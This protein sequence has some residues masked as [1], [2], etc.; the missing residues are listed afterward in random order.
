MKFTY[1][2]IDHGAEHEQYWQGCGAAN[3]EFTQV[4]TGVGVSALDAGDDALDQVAQELP[5]W[6]RENHDDYAQLRAEISE[7]SKFNVHDDC[8]ETFLDLAK[9]EDHPAR[10]NQD[11]ES[12]EIWHDDC[13]LHCNVSILWSFEE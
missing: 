6:L 8:Y 7:L 1:K 13:D 12:Y 3:T 10:G 5:R 9:D 11:F 2:L 4:V